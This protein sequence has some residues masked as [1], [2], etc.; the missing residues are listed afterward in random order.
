M[1]MQ[2][3]RDFRAKINETPALQEAI[4]PFVHPRLHTFQIAEMG[5]ENGFDFT[6][7]EVIE[8]YDAE[9]TRPNRE[10]SD[11]ELELV[12]GG[13]KPVGPTGGPE[14]PFGK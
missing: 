12:A 3:L 8:L 14:D 2:S 11:Y 6:Q 4:R 7:E 1:S 10:L 5:R 9:L 13:T